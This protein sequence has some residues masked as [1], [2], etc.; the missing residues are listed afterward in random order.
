MVCTCQISVGIGCFIKFSTK[1]KTPKLVHLYYTA[2]IFSSLSLFLSVS[3]RNY[4]FVGTMGFSCEFLAASSNL[5][6]SKV[7]PDMV[8]YHT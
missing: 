1:N 7:F 8:R 4:S 6:K 3:G 5:G 2:Y